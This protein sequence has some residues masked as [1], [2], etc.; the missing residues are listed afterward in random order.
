MLE[1]LL[2][3]VTGLV[4]VLGWTAFSLLVMTAILAVITGIWRLVG[5]IVRA[6]AARRGYTLSGEDV[7]VWIAILL[8]G[9]FI[10]F[11]AIHVGSCFWGHTDAK[12][13]H[14]E[15][16]IRKILSGEENVGLD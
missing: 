14:G 2:H 6:A 10:L 7:A 4:L 3:L 13:C 16:G 11:G 1:S 8:L 15:A 12:Y 9:M 5:A